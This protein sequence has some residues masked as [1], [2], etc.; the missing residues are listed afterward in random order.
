MFDW[1]LLSLLIWLPLATAVLVVMLGQSFESLVRPVALGGALVVLGLSVV[2]YLGFDASTAAYQFEERVAWIETFSVYYHLGIDG[3]ALPLILL[4]NLIG[5]LVIVGGWGIKDRPHLYMAAFLVLQGLMVGVFAAMDAMLFYV[6]FEA[7]LVPMF[8]IIGIWGGPNR[9][10][11]TIKF[12][13]FTFFGSV[14]MLIAL[15]WMYLAGG[16]FQITDLHQLPMALNAQILVFLAFLIAFAVKI[17]M[18]PV[19]TWLPDAH[20]EAPTGGSV[21]LAAVMLKIGG[22]GLV[23]FSL[24][25]TPDAAAALDWLVIGLSLV[26]ITYIGFV[27]LAQS[28]MKKLIAYSSISHMGF[29]TLG[30]FLAFAIGRQS[31]EFVGAGLGISGAMVQMVSHGFIS[32]AMFSAVGVLYDRVHSR[33]ISSYGGVANTMPW[34]AVF[35][36]LFFMSNS[37]LPGTSG[38]VGEFMVILA[39]FHANFW[40]AFVAATTLLLGAAYSLWLV[41][42]VFYGEVGNHSVAALKDINAREWVVLTTL[43][44]FVIAVGVWPFPLIDMME[45]SVS[46]LIDHILESKLK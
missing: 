42:R 6:F 27:A 23:R 38:F 44:F 33:E 3:L 9:I 28:D 18:W 30:L 17:P 16:S 20:V 12:F 35:A 41:K 1:P 46:H 24:P 39:A 21:V 36:V 40:F 5:V 19:H 37:G 11:A 10:Y 34:F 45:V 29:V 4:T 7:M 32:A 14:F 8:L 25:I 26:A 22:Y 15:I 2:L 31:G 13:L 43:A